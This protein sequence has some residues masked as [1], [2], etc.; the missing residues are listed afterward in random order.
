[1]LQAMLG[2]AHCKSEM[3]AEE[4]KSPCSSAHMLTLSTSTKIVPM[5]DGMPR[6]VM[7]SG[8]SMHGISLCISCNKG[9]HVL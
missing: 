5:A 1:M 6:A 8:M 7:S 3:H 2:L 4:D 9:E